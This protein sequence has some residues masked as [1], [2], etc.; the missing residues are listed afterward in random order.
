MQT[1]GST[2]VQTVPQIPLPESAAP[3]LAELVVHLIQCDPHAAIAAVDAAIGDHPPTDT[4]QCLAVVAEAIVAVR[5]PID[6]RDPRPVTP[7]PAAD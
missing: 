5:R 4:D 2:I 6:L 1:T 3:R 7:A